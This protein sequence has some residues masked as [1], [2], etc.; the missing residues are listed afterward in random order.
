[1][2]SRIYPEYIYDIFSDLSGIPRLGGR[3]T[4]IWN[5]AVVNSILLDIVRKD[6]LYYKT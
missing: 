4:D 6:L 5:K 3:K 2:Y 1:M